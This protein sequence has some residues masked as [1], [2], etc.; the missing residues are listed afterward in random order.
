MKRWRQLLLVNKAVELFSSN[1]ILSVNHLKCRN[2]TTKSDERLKVT[3][4][5][6][7][8]RSLP[9]SPHSVKYLPLPPTCIEQSNSFLNEKIWKNH[10]FILISTHSLRLHELI[11]DILGWLIT[12][13]HWEKVLKSN[14]CWSICLGGYF[15]S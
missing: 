2:D 12:K 5:H 13:N 10:F 9:K 1:P 4:L 7:K 15:G 11:C 14:F 6:T 3:I 8:M